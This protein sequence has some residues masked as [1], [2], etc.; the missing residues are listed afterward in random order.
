MR[1]MFQM[2]RYILLSYNTCKYVYMYITCTRYQNIL[3]FLFIFF[4][5]T[6][7]H[8]GEGPKLKTSVISLNY[9]ISSLPC[10]SL[11]LILHCQC[12]TSFLSPWLQCV[13]HS[14]RPILVLALALQSESLSEKFLRFWKAWVANKTI[15][16]IKLQILYRKYQKHINTRWLSTRPFESVTHC[17]EH[18]IGVQTVVGS[19]IFRLCNYVA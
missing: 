17:L 16:N 6:K 1:I 4:N 15:S 19:N 5:E 8:S 2:I 13:C 14:C 12:C 3:S 11:L 9:Y 18:L 10:F 7:L